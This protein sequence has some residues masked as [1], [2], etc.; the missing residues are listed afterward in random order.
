MDQGRAFWPAGTQLAYRNSD[1]SWPSISPLSADAEVAEATPAILRDELDDGRREDDQEPVREIHG[2]PDPHSE[3]RAPR[4]ARRP[5]LPTKADIEEHFP[6]HLNF[7]SWCEHCVAGK[8]RLAQHIVQ[9]SDRERLGVTVHMDY[10]FMT[11]EEAEET[12]QPTLVVY[13]DDKKAM[14]AL[15]VEQKGVT[16]GIV[17]YLVGVLDQSGY[18]GQKITIKSHQEPSI[19]ALKKAVSAERVGETVPIESPVR[20]SKSNGMMEN[21]VKLWQEQLRTIKHDAEARFKKRVEVDSVLFSW[22]IPYVSERSTST[23]SAWTA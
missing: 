2:P 14:W 12:M 6:L 7:R 11:P 18:Q 4:V 5:N 10:A 19:L 3:V 9:P 20:S 21:A 23:R 22:L 13:D 15:A 8:A 17:K 1:A 16:E